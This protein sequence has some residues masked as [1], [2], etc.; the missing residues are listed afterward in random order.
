MAAHGP[1]IAAAADQPHYVYATRNGADVLLVALN[2]DDR[3]AV[4]VTAGT[5]HRSGPDRCRL[6]R[7]AGGVVT[8]AEIGPHGWLIIEPR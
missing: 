7:A 2:I 1:D 6:G 3:A 4:V 5:R 8:E